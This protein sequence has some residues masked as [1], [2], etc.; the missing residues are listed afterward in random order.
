[1]LFCSIGDAIAT[2]AN[3]IFRKRQRA[4]ESGKAPKPRARKVQDKKGKYS[5][6]D[7]PYDD[8]MCSEQQNRIFGR[9]KRTGMYRGVC[10]EDSNE[11][12]SN[13]RVLFYPIGNT[14]ARYLQSSTQ[15]VLE[16]LK[17]GGI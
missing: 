5:L 10:V 9:L 7:R 12:A 8:A 4:I 13:G 6:P 16:G 14:T 15:R 3:G 2:T 1:M 17:D 11:T